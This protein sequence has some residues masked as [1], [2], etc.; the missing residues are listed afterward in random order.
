MRQTDRF[1]SRRIEME[2]GGVLETES[3]VSF[4]RLGCTRNMVDLI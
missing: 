1:W 4:D 2:V 3:V